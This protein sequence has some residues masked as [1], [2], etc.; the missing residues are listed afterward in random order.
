MYIARARA[1]SMCTHGVPTV[2]SMVGSF[3]GSAMGDGRGRSLQIF[4]PVAERPAADSHARAIVSLRSELRVLLG[5]VV[6]G[7]RA[8]AAAFRCARNK[9]AWK[10]DEIY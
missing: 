5:R 10:G 1:G 2:R 4:R 9:N 6:V 3:V 7:E 8:A